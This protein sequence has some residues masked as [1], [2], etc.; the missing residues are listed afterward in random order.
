[1]KVITMRDRKN[2]L[3]ILFTTAYNL[4][5]KK[6]NHH[7]QEKEDFDIKLVDQIDVSFKTI[8]ITG[9]EPTTRKDL[10]EAVRKLSHKGKVILSSNILE[11]DFTR[12]NLYRSA[13]LQRIDGWID[14]D[15]DRAYKE[16]TEVNAFQIVLSNIQEITKSGTEFVL[17]TTI[18]QWNANRLRE[19]VDLGMQCGVKHFSFHR[20]IP[21]PNCPELK[22]ISVTEYE[23]LEKD[24]IDYVVS[25]G[26]KLKI[27][28]KASFCTRPIYVHVNGDVCLCS[29][30]KIVI[31]SLKRDFLLAILAHADYL[32]LKSY[33]RELPSCRSCAH[34]LEGF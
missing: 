27:D 21:Q 24:I 6:C 34:F 11:I 32:L 12:L 2:K 7:L 5:C 20:L 4:R 16:L 31:G 30:N 3:K 8:R 18:S 14:T 23:Q 15:N 29:K 25:K 19:I 26:G 9:G 10:Q 17:N 13:G 33:T 1:M 28:K 22:S